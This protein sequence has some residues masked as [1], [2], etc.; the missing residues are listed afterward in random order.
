MKKIKQS[1]S[2]GNLPTNIYDADAHTTINNILR[3]SRTESASLELKQGILKLHADRQV[4][5]GIFDKV[6][7]TACGMANANYSVD[8]A[9][10]LIG[11]ADSEGDAKR[12]KQLDHIEPLKV[13]SHFIVGCQREERFSK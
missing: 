5:E 7:R 4:D 10:I 12:V 8:D 9:V 1:L 11:V 3:F 6:F 2:P 13:G